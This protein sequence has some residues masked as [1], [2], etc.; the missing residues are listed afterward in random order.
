MYR[1]RPAACVATFPQDTA[2]ECVADVDRE[3]GV[4]VTGREKTGERDRVYI[5]LSPRTS[6]PS[7]LSLSRPPSLLSP[8][9]TGNI[10]VLILCR[11]SPPFSSS[12]FL[13]STFA[14]FPRFV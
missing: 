10:E 9:W 1:R 4:A 8:P 12:C 2:A 11:C 7:D 14:P 5:T 3:S 13:A 6:I